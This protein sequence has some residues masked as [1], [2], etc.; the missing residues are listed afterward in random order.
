MG[1]PEA[2]QP[3]LFVFTHEAETQSTEGVTPRLLVVQGRV[4]TAPTPQPWSAVSLLRCGPQMGQDSSRVSAGTE[5][6]SAV[7]EAD[8]VQQW[9]LGSSA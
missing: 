7:E 4:V 8:S 1:R 9:V 5:D 2:S 3:D 6:A